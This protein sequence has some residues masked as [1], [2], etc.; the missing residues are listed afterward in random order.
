[1][2]ARAAVI[3]AAAIGV[4]IPWQGDWLERDMAQHMLIEFPL[5]LFAGA[6]IGYALDERFGATVERF[7]RMGLVGF[8]FAAATLSYWMI[9]AALDNSVL[10]GSVAAAKYI[11]LLLSGALLWSSFRLAPLAVQAFFVGSFVLMA[12]T[13]GCIYQSAPQRLCLNYLLD[14]QQLAGQGLVAAA[15]IV[16]AAWCVS[17]AGAVSEPDAAA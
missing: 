10:I 5:L 6:F 11:T 4:F 17:I 15:V 14:A 12:A 16:G 3:I 2:G 7:N 8:A 1:M 9:P 13:F